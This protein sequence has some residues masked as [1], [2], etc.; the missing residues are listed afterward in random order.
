M[1]EC[2]WLTAEFS[3]IVPFSYPGALADYAWN[4]AANQARI[5]TW[6]QE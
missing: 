3:N 6:E 2:Q 5:G 1:A 4:L